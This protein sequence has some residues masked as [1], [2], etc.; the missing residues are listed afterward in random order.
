M[1]DPQKLLSNA[2]RDRNLSDFMYTLEFLNA[3]PNHE[4]DIAGRT[5]FQKILT[6]PNSAEYIRLCIEN[7]AECYA[8]TA[9]DRYPLHL[10]L[11]S[12][13]PRN[14]QQF[15]KYHD[16]S[17]VN[18]KF[19]DKNS[20][21]LLIEKLNTENYDKV[22]ECLKIL[23][24]HGC[25]PNYP[26]DSDE[27]PFHQ[28]MNKNATLNVEE[29]LRYFVN[30]AEIDIYT[31]RQDEM[32]S[33]YKRLRLPSLSQQ[34]QNID[35]KFMMKLAVNSK[36][37]E[38]EGYFK[39]FKESCYNNEESFQ[40][41]C[42]KL[43]EM[44][45]IKGGT[46]IVD[47][48]LQNVPIDINVRCKQ[49]T[50]L[51]PPSFIAC[52]KGHYKILE[53]FLKQPN[54]IFCYEKP[55][56]PLF[57]LETNTATTMLH[58]VCLRF[59]AEKSDDDNVDFQKCFDLLINDP[60]C[61]RDT[62]INS[63]DP[64]GCT[65]L[66]YSTR[67]KN[68]AAT[69]ALLKK[70][71]YICTPNNLG[72]TALDD[73]NKDT[74]ENFLD[75][76]LVPLTRR[77]QQTH[78]YV[79]GYDKQ[80]L[81]ID[82]SFLMPPKNSGHSE[83]TPLRRITK[84]TE[85]RKLIKHP[86]LFS[87]LYIKWSK[88]S[89]LFMINFI[90]FSLFLL[91]F[92]FYIVL[93]Q[94]I[95]LD[96]RRSNPYYMFFYGISIVFV[97]MLTFRE[98]MQCLFSIKYYF[99]S[100]MNWFEIVLIV[101]SFLVL[102]GSFEENFQRILRGI[103]ILFAATEFLTLAGALPN[104][105]ISTH[106]V[107]LRTVILT[108]LKS[109]AL[110]SILLFGFA[111]CFFTL[112]GYDPSQNARGNSTTV[113]E[114]DGQAAA[115][116]SFY[117]PGI[118]IIKTFVMLTGEFEF[119]NLELHDYTNYIIFV[120]FVF[121]ITIVLF[122]LLNALAVS[123]TQQ[124]KSEGQLIDLIQRI[125]VLNKYEKVITTG[126]SPLYL[127]CGWLTRLLEGTTNVFQKWIPTGQVVVFTNE[128]NEIRTIKNPVKAP[129]DIGDEEMQ[130]LNNNNSGS[131]KSPK[132]EN[133]IVNEWLP[134]KFQKPAVMDPKIMKSIKHVLEEK[135][136]RSKEE[137]KEAYR[138]KMDEKILRDMISIKMQNNDNSDVYRNVLQD[139]KRMN[140]KQ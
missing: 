130:T 3:N 91:S 98:V 16:S 106:M 125:S 58:E 66:H 19:N 7:G 65:P 112:F 107:I 124:I 116:P 64:Y 94:S 63:K 122:N 131:A 99:K 36:E 54:V 126:N 97:I 55:K 79:Y 29:L 50:W 39:A 134:A 102:F 37:T 13:C 20:L 75:E 24:N 118:A 21:H 104:L 12:Q 95:E 101:L 53:L 61:D 40:D 38:F 52:M 4:S 78:M 76:C 117:H 35:P 69:M 100:K 103:T 67:Y 71:A 22:I 114:N 49:A 74:F 34:V 57:V 120:L 59:G 92:I 26:N 72:K 43:L 128:Q 46:N 30:N 85:L 44:G 80:E 133:I 18:A 139:I 51:Y 56:D 82:Y 129:R 15:L 28:L 73:M 136:I 17:K 33:K 96:E 5:L 109:I 14:L 62:V 90:M 9:D 10:V 137:E 25:N 84:N 140:I 68:E 138:K 41:E 81:H 6:K 23:L 123:D 108:F 27:T 45:T 83:I 110:Y 87:F 8:K 121:L 105:S 42:A 111:L 60:R 113:S 127:C 132:Y 119:G 31:Y 47:I 70:S 88:L 1:P 93:C 77:V 2:F 115:N 135:K 89:L 11:E 48:I 86:V 32:V